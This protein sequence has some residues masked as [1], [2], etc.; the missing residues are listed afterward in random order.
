LIHNSILII[1]NFGMTKKLKPIELRN[2]TPSADE[3]KSIKRNP[4]YFIL[5]DVLDTYNVGTI[6]RLADAIAV[7]KI[8]L[9]AGTQTPPNTKVKKASVN[10]WQWVNWEYKK[11]ALE[12]INEL[13]A[14]V[15]KIKIMAVE[16]AKNSRPYDKVKYRL[17]LALVV[18]N[19]TRG[20]HSEVLTATDSIVELPLLGI[21]TS[22]N[23]IVALSVV[24]YQVLESNKI[25]LK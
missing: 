6:F 12:A 23:V 18:G 21:N 3:V 8:Y 20:V 22:L 14:D 9:C 4:V 1:I 16:Q 25:R 10:T 5:D 15:P 19:E 13:R 11:T 2:M 17:P 24:A 7:E